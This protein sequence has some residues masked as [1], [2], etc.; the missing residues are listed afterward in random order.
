VGQELAVAG[1]AW[2]TVGVPGIATVDVTLDGSSR[3]RV[4]RL[5][6]WKLEWL[7]TIEKLRVESAGS[8]LLPG[9]SRQVAGTELR[10]EVMDDGDLVGVGGF[11]RLQQVLRQ[12]AAELDRA[13]EFEAVT[14]WRLRE[15]E[16]D[17]WNE[18]VHAL[19]GKAVVLGQAIDA[20]SRIDL[21]HGRLLAHQVRLTPVEWRPCVT[22]RCVAVKVEYLADPEAVSR[23]VNAPAAGLIPQLAELDPTVKIRGVEVLGGGER[24]IDPATMLVF[25]ENVT[26]KLHLTFGWEDGR[27]LTLAAIDGREMTTRIV[28][29]GSPGS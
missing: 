27:S 4:K 20:T 7:E 10:Y 26:R 25:A 19:V 11:D 21:G 1:K 6:A 17:D 28:G 15:R 18:R 14:P 5:S 24:V 16:R 12:A 29:S 13:E 3:V 23:V 8:D 22:G 9:V 2:R